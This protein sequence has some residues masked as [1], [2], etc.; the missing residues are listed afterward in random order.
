MAYVR[1]EVAAQPR[2]HAYRRK[3]MNWALKFEQPIVLTSGREIRSLMQ[4]R[5]FMAELP[6]LDRQ[7]DHWECT[8][9]LIFEA[10]HEHHDAALEIARQQML[11]SLRRKSLI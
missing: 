8:A 2:P 1:S 10:A 5:D 7:Q 3:T 6:A 4:A 9:D 11:L